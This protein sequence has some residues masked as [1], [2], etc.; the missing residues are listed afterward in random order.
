MLIQQD[1][2]MKQM[3]DDVLTVVL[4]TWYLTSFVTNT[5]VNTSSYSK[6]TICFI[7]LLD[8]H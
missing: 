1:S 6:N 3:V 8:K 4:L 7:I 2:G 5:T